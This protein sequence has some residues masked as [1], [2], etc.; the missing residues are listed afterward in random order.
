ML[1]LRD[2]P[3]PSSPFSSK[4][5][6]P[7]HD[8]KSESND[9]FENVKCKSCCDYEIQIQSLKDDVSELHKEIIKLRRQKRL[10]T[11]NYEL[12]IGDLNKKLKKNELDHKYNSSS[13]SIIINLEGQSVVKSKE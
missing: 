2:R 7:D 8:H 9:G 11:E 3:P 4:K 5:A 6:M 10:M 12:E 1:D 13:I